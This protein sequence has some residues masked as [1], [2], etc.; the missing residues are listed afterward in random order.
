MRRVTHTLLGATAALPLALGV[1]PGLALG[2]IWWGMVGGG[3]PDWVDLRSDLRKP[4]RLRHRG[5][6]HSVF[7]GLIATGGIYWALTILMA[8]DFRVARVSLAPSQ[9]AVWLW[10][11]SFA[12]GVV[13]H[14]LGDA[15]TVAGI[16][17]LL[18]F[19]SVRIWVLPRP[20]RSRSDGV[21][22]RVGRFLALATIL[23][24]TVLYAARTLGTPL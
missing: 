20:L 2:C 18:P 12:L 5:V 6:S 10:S 15:C 24:G 11:A 7:A 9:D 8:A 19:S 23:G 1:E 4:L 17:P 21:V 16:R 14:L 22:D 13:S 3:F